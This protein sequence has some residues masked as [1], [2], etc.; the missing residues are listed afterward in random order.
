MKSPTAPA[1]LLCLVLTAPPRPAGAAYI[2][3]LLSGPTTADPAAV[4]WNPAAMTLMKG[5]HGMLF[6]AFSA[7]RLAYQRDTPS[8]VDG[9]PFPEATTTVAG[10][11]PTVHV[12]TDATLE[13]FR[14][15]VGLSVPIADGASWPA[16]TGGRPSSTRYYAL[17]GKDVYFVIGV[18]AAYRI[19]RY[20]SIGVGLDILGIWQAVDSMTD[21]GA[22]LNQLTCAWVGASS[23]PLDAPLSREDPTYQGLTTAGGVGYS[24]GGYGG[25][26]LEPFR[27]LRLGVGFH[28]G[29]RVKVP[30]D[31]TVEIPGSVISYVTQNLPSVT[32]PPLE[33]TLE[34]D[35][36][37][38]MVATAGVAVTAAD[39]LELAADLH[40]LGKSAT[41]VLRMQVRQSSTSLVGEQVQAK[42]RRDGYLFGV[43][44]NY[45]LLD[46][47]R[48]ALRIEYTPNSRPAPYVSPVSLDFDRLALHVGAAWTAVPW[49]T[50]T[51]EYGHYFTWERR[52]TV[53]RY[54]PNPMPATPEEAGFDLPPATGWYDVGVDRFGLGMLLHF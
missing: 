48:L 22:R 37:A 41:E 7:I 12:V 18:A 42:G 34:I 9:L 47:L 43:Q 45:Q 13:R 15:G 5:T 16:T 51:L 23:C 2:G 11:D 40:W 36:V 26:L 10:F 53:S 33:A 1:A 52:I 17:E 28:S 19:T 32:L 29:G 4:Y 14:F 25:V 8:P 31:V 39:R 21:F 3:N 50:L 30:I 20:L 38:P 49:L 44:G 24:V 27:W 6:S 35:G 54:G 46:N